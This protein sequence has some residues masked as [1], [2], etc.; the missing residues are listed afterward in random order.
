MTYE[1]EIACKE[2]GGTGE[3]WRV[4]APDDHEL[5]AC[6]KCG[7]SGTI[8]IK[9]GSSEDDMEWPDSQAEWS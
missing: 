5:L 2:C 6:D 9:M 7:G 8:T 1:E 3:D 4:I